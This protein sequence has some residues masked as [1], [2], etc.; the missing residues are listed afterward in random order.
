MKLKLISLFILLSVII[1][2]CGGK[3]DEPQEAEGLTPQAETELLNSAKTMFNFLPDKMPMSENDTPEMIELGKKLFNETKLSINGTQSCNTCHDLTN[4]KAGVDN[5]RVSPGALPGKEGRRNSPTVLNAGYHFLQFWDGRAKDLVE[6]AKGPILNPDEMSMKSEKDVEK[7]IAA[8]PEYTEMFAKAFPDAKPAITYNNIAM[9]IA[10]FERTLISKGR[11]DQWLAGNAKAL[12]AA[13]KIG[14]KTFMDVGCTTCHSGPMFGAILFQK[15]GLVK[16][17]SNTTDLGRFEL[18]KLDMDKFIFKTS[19]LRNTMLT[20][21]YFHDGN[22]ATMADAIRIMA[23]INL[24]KTL[25][26]DQIKAI[27]DFLWTLT[28][29]GLEQLNKK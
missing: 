10:A 6:Q 24:G 3:K 27:E 29:V 13:E 4:N 12:T 7:V 26:G 16:P 22:A 9:A 23:D 28:D 18:T 8:I 20:A 14:L 21:P 25:T 15:M 11:F 19:T 17:Y 5:K 1:I 2:A